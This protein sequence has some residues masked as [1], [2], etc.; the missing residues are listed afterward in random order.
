VIFETEQKYQQDIRIIL[1]GEMGDI[2]IL[3]SAKDL[4]PLS[5]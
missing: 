1:Q 4:L 2:Y 5:F 3:N